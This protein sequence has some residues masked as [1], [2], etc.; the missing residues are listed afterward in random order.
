MTT[1]GK[2]SNR[3][4][5]VPP[6]LADQAPVTW[7]TGERGICGV[8]A[9]S[10]RASLHLGHG[11]GLVG[12]GGAGGKNRPTREATPACPTRLAC[13]TCP[14]WQHA[15]MWAEMHVQAAT[16]VP[17]PEQMVNK[18]AFA[19]ASDWPVAGYTDKGHPLQ[20]AMERGMA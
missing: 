18:L 12:G 5:T 3:P 16:A 8:R 10:L 17:A 11:L 15:L 6:A 2:G 13:L 9:G 20:D 4:S 14:P 19:V 7:G 1:I